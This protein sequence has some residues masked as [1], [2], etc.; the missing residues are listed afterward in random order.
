MSTV[1]RRWL[2]VLALSAAVVAW[3][4]WWVVGV[5]AVDGDAL[6][7]TFGVPTSVLDD[8]PANEIGDVGGAFGGVITTPIGSSD[9][10]MLVAGVGALVCARSKAPRAARTAR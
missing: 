6:L 1:A 8:V 7:A 2:Y 5:Y 4:M 3:S 10:A 9:T